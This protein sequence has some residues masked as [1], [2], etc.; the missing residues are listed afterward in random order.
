MHVNA[1]KRLQE[2]LNEDSA[3]KAEWKKTFKLKNDPRVTWIGKFLRKTS[4]DE[5]PQFLNVL[6][7]EMS[8][9]GARPIVQKELS[10]LLTFARTRGFYRQGV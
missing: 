3:A 5:F 2:I 4:L 9:V 6:K 7:G 8:V 10:G 1:D